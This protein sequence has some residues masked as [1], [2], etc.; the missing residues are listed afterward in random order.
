M[1]EWMD[2]CLIV[3]KDKCRGR[4]K[5]ELWEGNMEMFLISQ[6]SFPWLMSEK[7]LWGSLTLCLSWVK[8]VARPQKISGNFGLYQWKSNIKIQRSRKRWWPS[9][10][11]LSCSHCPTVLEPV[12]W[13]VRLGWWHQC[14][15][16]IGDTVR[17]R[18]LWSLPNE[19]VE[20]P[21]CSAWRRAKS[22]MI[23]TVSGSG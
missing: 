4:W 8:N 18:N 16:H 21:R 14:L 11:D 23:I 5:E 13:S 1:N 20:K 6:R 2:N 12:L 22:G 15:S 7:W 10:A 19:L 9:L 3:W 17:R